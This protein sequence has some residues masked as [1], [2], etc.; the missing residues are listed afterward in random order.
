M[1]HIS[2]TDVRVLDNPSAFL[3]PISF[4]ICFECA[5]PLTDDL[6]WRCVYVGSAESEEHDQVLD[7]VL[8][9]PVSVGS[10]RFIFT[11]PHPDPSRIPKGDLL[12]VTVL[13]LTCSYKQAEFIRIGYYVSNEA[14]TD[15]VVGG[16]SGKRKA[17]GEADEAAAAG[18]SSAAAAADA[19][20]SGPGL[21]GD[22]DGDGYGEG[23]AEAEADGDEGDG[24]DLGGF[25]VADD[26]EGGDGEDEAADEDEEMG[27][28]E[29]AAEDAT[30]TATPTTI[31]S[32][33]A[34]DIIRN[35]LADKPVVTRFAIEWD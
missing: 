29:E 9:G 26:E 31:T 22:G 20:A 7:D 19:V 14:R 35:V 4:E 10:N 27:D 15:V 11:C 1:A 25:I 33:S 12:G 21:G 3:S 5:Q 17:E 23:D 16:E 6:E 32:C 34:A 2:V 28:V 24:D 8:V 30:T 18:S 13:L